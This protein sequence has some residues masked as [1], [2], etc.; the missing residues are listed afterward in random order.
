MS[1]GQ[2]MIVRCL[3]WALVAGSAVANPI[4]TWGPDF[5]DKAVLSGNSGFTLTLPSAVSQPVPYVTDWTA[6][7]LPGALS[8]PT[9]PMLTNPTLAMLFG[10]QGRPPEPELFQSATLNSPA[11]SPGSASLFAPEGDASGGKGFGMLF[12]LSTGFVAT[13]N[14]VQTMRP[15]ALQGFDPLRFQSNYDP[16]GVS[17]PEPGTFVLVGLAGLAL[18]AWKRKTQ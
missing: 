16:F 17:S 5:G 7:A 18:V 3:V 15:S 2:A 9:G 4:K 6:P 10:N 12:T 13:S 11:F 14:L 8:A 1:S